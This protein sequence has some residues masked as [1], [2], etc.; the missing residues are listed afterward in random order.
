MIA[1]Q[2][3][4]VWK[5]DNGRQEF[6]QWHD[7]APAW[8]WFARLVARWKPQEVSLFCFTDEGTTVRLAYWAEEV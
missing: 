5:R 8:K 7:L 1:T 4:V 3:R 2:F 6:L